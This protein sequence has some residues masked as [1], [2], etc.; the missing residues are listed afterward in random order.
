M[1]E[2]NDKVIINLVSPNTHASEAVGMGQT[3]SW[4]EERSQFW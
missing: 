4:E 1:M 3:D 2:N